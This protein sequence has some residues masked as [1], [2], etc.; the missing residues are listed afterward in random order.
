MLI[1]S[2]Y[3]LNSETNTYLC[4][5]ITIRILMDE[6]IH[7]NYIDTFFRCITEKNKVCENMITDH[8]LAYVVS[9]EMILQTTDKRTLLKNGEAVFIRRNHLVRKIKQPGRNGEPFKGLF[10]H[11]SA[12]F[13][14]KLARQIMIPN[15]QPDKAL[16]N[17]LQ[18]PIPAHPFLTGLFQSLDKY[19][20]MGQYPS[21][22]L[23][24]A[25]L[26]EAVLVILQLKP[27]LGSLLFDFKEQWKPDLKEFMDKNF[28]SDLTVEEF[29]HYTGRSLSTFKRDFSETYKE[30]PNRWIVKRRLEKAYTLLQT[31]HEQPSEV[32]LKVGF[33]NLSH[34]STAFK[35]QFGVA[36]SLI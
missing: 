11:L 30:T 7:D 32:Y 24:E 31:H 8:M 29:A 16:L 18:I 17:A 36:P 6:E 9:G 27:S 10:L 1:I 20:S 28:M 21:K 5:T 12:S 26:H 14:R 2:I 34:F 3:L 4:T 35:K 25:K 23:V 15:V 19:F 13:L 33:K 22:E